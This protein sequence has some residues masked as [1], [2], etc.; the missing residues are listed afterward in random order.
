MTTKLQK[1]VSAIEI[2]PEDEQDAIADWLLAELDSERR[3][4]DLFA[5]SAG[6]L[7]KMAQEAL[8]EHKAGRTRELDPEKL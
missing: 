3:W 7:E 5:R 6:L 4:D 8:A 2:L 1:A